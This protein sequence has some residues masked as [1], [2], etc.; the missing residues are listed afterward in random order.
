MAS[1]LSIDCRRTDVQAV[2]DERQQLPHPVIGQGA[3]I[4]RQTDS[5][6]RGVFACRSLSAGTLVE[7]SHVLLFPP[8]EYHRFGR[9]TRLDDYTYVWSKSSSGSTMALALG[10]GEP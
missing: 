6:G 1:G 3:L 8:D 4:V 5:A 7:V 2:D 10:I 9:H